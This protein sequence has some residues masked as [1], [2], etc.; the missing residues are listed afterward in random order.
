MLL[1]W[2]NVTRSTI[3]SWNFSIYR[4]IL[5]S[6]NNQVNYHLTMNRIV[7]AWF[8]FLLGSIN[9]TNSIRGVT[10]KRLLMTRKDAPAV[11]LE[12]AIQASEA[13]NGFFNRQAFV[14]FIE[15]HS[16]D[17][18]NV[19]E[20]QDLDIALVH[21]YWQTI[22]TYDSEGCITSD[23]VPIDNLLQT[24][25]RYGTPLLEEMCH[26]INLYLFET[27]LTFSPTASPTRIPT[28]QPTFVPSATPSRLPSTEP[29]ISPSTEPS[30]RPTKLPSLAPSRS[31]SFEPSVLPSNEPSLMK[32]D[33]PSILPTRQPSILPS[34]EPSY[35]PTTV[36]TIIP[37]RVPSIRPSQ[38]PTIKPSQLPTTTLSQVPTR[39]VSMMPSVSQY[40]SIIPSAQFSSNPS[41]SP[42]QTSSQ[43][44]SAFPSGEP[45]SLPSQSL[46]PS[47]QPSWG[48]SFTLTF[49][50][51]MAK[52]P[53][54]QM[55]L[56]NALNEC[57]RNG[58]MNQIA[59]LDEVCSRNDDLC[60]Y[61]WQ[62]SVDLTPYRKFQ[63]SACVCALHL[64]CHVLFSK[65]KDALSTFSYHSLIHLSPLLYFHNRML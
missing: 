54:T 11:C 47:M 8:T 60:P 31:P 40:P 61:S 46:I 53:N 21:I 48:E 29:S 14:D 25:S 9:P 5:K 30:L 57:I 44:P 55:T 35:Q 1:R 58:F 34:A 15:A 32:S 63:M 43:E 49:S 37:S 56:S 13:H 6:E 3:I 38:G 23:E 28:V 24:T 17:A 64:M 41:Q 20:F 36:P 2:Y 22:C 27:L 10:A 39:T 59:S 45:S 4:M 62:I 42:T 65:E 50:M 33:V 7:F 51:E 16:N 52:D 19:M 26:R 12:N 18:I